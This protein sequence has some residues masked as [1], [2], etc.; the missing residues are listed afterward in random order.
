[1]RGFRAARGMQAPIELSISG[2]LKKLYADKISE[3]H[4]LLPV[5]SSRSGVLSSTWIDRKNGIVSEIIRGMTL[6]T[7]CVCVCVFVA[8]YVSM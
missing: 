6:T 1:M 8:L 7:A 2:P 3:A 5:S 4:S